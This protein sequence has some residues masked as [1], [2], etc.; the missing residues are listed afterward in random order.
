MGQDKQFVKLCRR[1]AKICYNSDCH[2]GQ[3]VLKPTIYILKESHIQTFSF[4]EHY[5][6]KLSSYSVLPAK[7][8]PKIWTVTD[9]AHAPHSVVDSLP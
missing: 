6:F 1:T 3:E 2:A 4:N 5:K 7:G 9:I 8:E